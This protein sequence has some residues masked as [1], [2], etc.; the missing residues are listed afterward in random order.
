MSVT[1]SQ[2]RQSQSQIFEEAQHTPVA[3][4]S[5]GS[6]VRAFVVSPSFFARAVEALEDREDVQAAELARGESVE[7]SHEDLKTKLVP[8]CQK[9]NTPLRLEDSS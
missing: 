4:T 2:F 6:R 3:I 8:P 7:I 9:V 5:R 1:S